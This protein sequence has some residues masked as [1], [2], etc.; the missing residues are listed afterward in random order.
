MRGFTLIEL[1]VVVA[2]IGI[3][4]AIAYPSYQEHLRNSRRAQAMADLSELAVTMERYHSVNNTY[5][6][7]VLAFEASPRSGTAA[8]S[9]ALDGEATASAF[10]VTAKP[11]T[12]GA[13]VNDKCGTLS[14]DQAGVK[15]HSSGTASECW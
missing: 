11:V 7:A 6:N 1:M 10:K 4:A 2:V 5:A 14:L 3:L 12:G 9:L 15:G 13:Q 8:Y